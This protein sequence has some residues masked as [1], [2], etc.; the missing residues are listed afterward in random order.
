MKIGVKIGIVLALL[1]G[2]YTSAWA[3]LRI[4]DQGAGNEV[5]ISVTTAVKVL[6]ADARR[7]NWTMF[8]ES[9]DLRCTEGTYNVGSGAFTAPAVTPTSTRGFII[10]SGQYVSEK[11]ILALAAGMNGSHQFTDDFAKVEI[12]CIST[13]GATSVDTWEERNPTSNP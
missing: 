12:D 3:T 10:K 8:S 6:A 2:I 11:S 13:A 4:N 5:P 7:F 1:L 9:V